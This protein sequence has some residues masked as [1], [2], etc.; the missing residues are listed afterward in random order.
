[1]SEVEIVGVPEA[2]AAKAYAD[3]DKYLEMYQASVDDPDGFWREHGQCI[4]WIKPYAQV[5]D[6]SYAADD[7]HVRWFYDGTLN[8]SANCLDRHLESRGDQVALICLLSAGS[9]LTARDFAFLRKSATSA[10][11]GVASVRE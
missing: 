10:L 4:D 5:K 3:N 7:L 1:M 9:T 6:V 2:W 11:H 8:A